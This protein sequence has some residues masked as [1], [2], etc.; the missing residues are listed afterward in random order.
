[1]KYPLMFLFILATSC[2][3]LR[4]YNKVAADPSRDSKEVA[5]LAQVCN[6]TFPSK[7]VIIYKDSITT[8]FIEDSEAI[9]QLQ[10]E[11]NKLKSTECPKLN[12]DS[13]LAK[14]KGGQ[15]IIT[16]Y[17]TKETIKPD[18]PKEQLL[19][20]KISQLE[21]EK[22]EVELALQSQK[23]TSRE[24]LEKLN[25][26]NTKL[27]SFNKWKWFFWGL[28]GL[29]GVYVVGRLGILKIPFIK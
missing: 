17:L 9:N 14:C 24:L 10:N 28:V 26:A 4:H 23:N 11:L 7:E 8:E 5:I 25:E 18:K 21:K 20:N 27:V 13:I 16:K 15:T 12:V 19:E 2:S 29:L 6:S 1:M 3:S 22:L